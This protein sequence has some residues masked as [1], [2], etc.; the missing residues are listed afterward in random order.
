MLGAFKIWMVNKEL[1]YF[2]FSKTVQQTH[3]VKYKPH[4]GSD[5]TQEFD[6][7]TKTYQIP[8]S[9]RMTNYPIGETNATHSVE[10]NKTEMA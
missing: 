3:K 7:T 4:M 8:G 5:L 1:K 9:F 6:A 10:P 2:F